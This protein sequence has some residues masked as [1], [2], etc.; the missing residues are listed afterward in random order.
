MEEFIG[1]APKAGKVHADEATNEPARNASHS[2]A[3]GAVQA[4][5]VELAVE[6]KEETAVTPPAPVD[7]QAPTSIPS[8][9]PQQPSFQRPQQGYQPRNNFQ[10]RYDRGQ[11]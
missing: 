8:A 2:D 3:G 6:K 1:T 11:Q 9:P 5:V 4:P 10:P 7:A